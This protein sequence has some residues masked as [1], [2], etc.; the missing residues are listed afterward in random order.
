MDN[1][2]YK[3]ELDGARELIQQLR[4]ECS[5]KQKLTDNALEMT[6]KKKN[7]R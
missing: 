7:E 1:E 6:T 2:I 3:A 4:T 5:V